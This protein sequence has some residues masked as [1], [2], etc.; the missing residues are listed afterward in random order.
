MGPTPILKMVFSY[1]L[2]PR[3]WLLGRTIREVMGGGGNFRAARVFFRYIFLAGIFFRMQELFFWATRCAWIFFLSIFPC[4]NLIVFLFA[5]F[6]V[7]RSPSPLHGFCNGPS[8]A[9]TCTKHAFPR[10]MA[11]GVGQWPFWER[12]GKNVFILDFSEKCTCISDYL[13]CKWV[14]RKREMFVQ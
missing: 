9:T 3:L 8:L 5:C 7:L 12:D 10:N 6:F 2:H 14:P 13:S 4:M 11:L 1:G